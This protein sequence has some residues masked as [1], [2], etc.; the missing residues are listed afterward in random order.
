MMVR[1]RRRVLTPALLVLTA[2]LAVG[3]T[4]TSTPTSPPTAG[5]TGT[6][7]QDVH[8]KTVSVLGLWSG[9]EL[10]GFMAVKSAW[11]HQ[12]AATVHWQGTQN[13]A[14]TLTAAIQAGNPPDIAVLPNPG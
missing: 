7:S 4:P 9:P 1:R 8:G 5:A 12:T 13:L 10:D 11:E 6:A 14:E 2:A 3:C